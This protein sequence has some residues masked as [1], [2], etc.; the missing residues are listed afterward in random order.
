MQTKSWYCPRDSC[1][2][3][4]SEATLRLET[5]NRGSQNIGTSYKVAK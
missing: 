3:A 5:A 4:R 2:R 1:P